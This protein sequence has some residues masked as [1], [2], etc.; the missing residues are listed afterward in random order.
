MTNKELVER[1]IDIAQN[2]KTVY[3]LGM[4]GQPISKSIITRKS[5][6]LPSWYTAAKKERLNAKIGTGTFGFDCVCLIKAV[7]WGWTGDTSK[8]NGGAVYTSNGVPDFGSDSLSLW[9][10]ISD[11]FNSVIP[12]EILWMKG[13]VGLYIGNGLCVEC[14]PRWKNKVQITAV[15]N[16]G[17]KAGY[18]CRT[19][20][21]HAQ[22]PWVEYKDKSDS[23]IFENETETSSDTENLVSN[24][25][26]A[27]VADGYT[28]PKYGIDGIWGSEC[29][30]VARK[31]IVKKRPFVYSNRAL[32]KFVQKQFGITADGL[33]GKDTQTAIKEF[34][35][36]NDLDADGIVGINTW[37]KLLKVKEVLL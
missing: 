20:T 24:W 31:A 37:K 36:S 28:F 12:G 6:Q 14:S 8:S 17:Q 5:A 23:T 25:Q 1:I 26:T 18:N 19:W 22:L 33:C 16:V 3:A 15:A 27:A 4:W 9:E 10:N 29:E 11:D 32:T 30:S 13:H 7:L 35:K 21:K 2:H 34:Q